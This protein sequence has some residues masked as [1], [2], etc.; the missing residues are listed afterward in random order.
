MDDGIKLFADNE[1]L[2][3]E[4]LVS[5]GVAQDPYQFNAGSDEY[6]RAVQI[7]KKLEDNN[8]LMK[9]TE[10]EF[11]K[12]FR[13]SRLIFLTAPYTETSKKFSNAYWY[14]EY[15]TVR[16][17]SD[18]SGVFGVLSYR[19]YQGDDW[20]VAVKQRKAGPYAV[21]GADDWNFML[22]PKA[23]RGSDYKAILYTPSYPLLLKG[24]KDPEQ[25]TFVWNELCEEYVGLNTMDSVTR[26]G[27]EDYP[28]GR[29]WEGQM[30][31]SQRD[32]DSI[33]K[34][35][36]RDSYG[37]NLK[38][39]SIWDHVLKAAMKADP[40]DYEGINR[41]V[42]QYIKKNLVADPIYK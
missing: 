12:A 33:R 22:F 6:K 11:C 28:D 29:F 34:I 2:I 5:A 14:Y 31:N 9:G 40:T 21:T 38:A 39:S 27:G 4:L 42:E 23:D 7:Y 36:L 13:D 18:L 8:L 35:A 24:V 10:D 37:D 15:N 17:I 3:R 25:V 26:R 16:K 19:G 1:Y 41:K 30:N 32:L 20:T